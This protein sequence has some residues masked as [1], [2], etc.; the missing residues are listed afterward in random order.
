MRGEFHVF[1]KCHFIFLPYVYEFHPFCA[2]AKGYR[3]LEFFEK[4]LFP[5]NSNTKNDVNS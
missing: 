4:I 2:F 5:K 1:E 3:V